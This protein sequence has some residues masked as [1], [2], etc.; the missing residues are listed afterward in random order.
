MIDLS[1]EVSDMAKEATSMKYSEIYEAA[2][3]MYATNDK[4]KKIG[5]ALKLF[6]EITDADCYNDHEFAEIKLECANVIEEEGLEKQYPE[7]YDW[8]NAYPDVYGV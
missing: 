8:L 1:N 6:E 4:L 5:I 2:E 3:D 7:I